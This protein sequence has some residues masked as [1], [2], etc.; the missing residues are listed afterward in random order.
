MEYL[1]NYQSDYNVSNFKLHTII[2]DEELTDDD[3]EYKI[4]S[5]FEM[6]NER[7]IA[8]FETIYN[9]GCY[10]Y[11]IENIDGSTS[12]YM[13]K[14]DTLPG[15]VSSIEVPLI[16]MFDLTQDALEYP[17]SYVMS[18]IFFTVDG[19]DKIDRA[20]Q[21]ANCWNYSGDVFGRNN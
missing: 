12:D 2:A 14:L 7:Q 11:Y 9:S 13:N 17:N 5:A 4:Q 18:E 21:L 1:E 6:I 3:K 20:L 16:V 19:E 10:G 8:A 15:D